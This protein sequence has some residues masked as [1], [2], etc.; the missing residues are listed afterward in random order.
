MY[1]TKYNEYGDIDKN[2]STLASKGHSQKHDVDHTGFCT[3]SKVEYG[4]DDYCSSETEK[5]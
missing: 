3:G 1:E 5:L 4:E 2:K